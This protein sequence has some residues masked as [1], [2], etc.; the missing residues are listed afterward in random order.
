MSITESETPA[1]V[2]RSTSFTTRER[3]TPAMACSTFTRML[4]NFRFACFWAAV[5]CPPRGFF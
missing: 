2:F 1:L 5:S 4:D 3:L